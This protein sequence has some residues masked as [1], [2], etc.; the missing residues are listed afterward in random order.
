MTERHASAPALIKGRSYGLCLPT[1]SCLKS[2]GTT[3][4]VTISSQFSR[5][6]TEWRALPT[7]Q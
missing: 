6:F 3:A 2:N 4:S 7:V 5:Q 1:L